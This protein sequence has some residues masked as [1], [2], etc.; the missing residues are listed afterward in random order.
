MNA[1]IKG[2]MLCDN[3]RAILKKPSDA[4]TVAITKEMVEAAFH[5]AED[6]IQK[7]CIKREP[8]QSFFAVFTERLKAALATVPKEKNDQT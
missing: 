3:C 6:H 7:A 1:H 4:A 2:T 8:Y 5:D